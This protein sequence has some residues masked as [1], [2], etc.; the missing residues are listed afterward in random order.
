MTARSDI[1][2]TLDGRGKSLDSTRWS[3]KLAENSYGMDVAYADNLQINE[4][5]MSAW[6]PIA[7]GNARDGQ[8]DVLLVTGIDT[9]RHVKNPLVLLDHGKHIALPIGLMETRDTKQYTFAIDPLTK[10]AGGRCY[11]YQ[12]GN[13]DYLPAGTDPAGKAFL[14]NKSQQFEHAVLCEQL[15]DMMAKR[16]LRS[17]SIGYQVQ[18]A[19]RIPAD[20]AT[21]IPQGLFLKRVLMLEGSLVVLPANQDTVRKA[22]AMP[23]ICGRPP[24]EMLVKSL[25][26][27]ASKPNPVVI[28]GFSPKIDKTLS[29]TPTSEVRKVATKALDGIR[30]KYRQTKRLKRKL[31][32]SSKGAAVV[33]IER[34][35]MDRAREESGKLGLKFSHMGTHSSG[36]EKVKLIGDDDNIDHVAKMFGK[37]MSFGKSAKPLTKKKSLPGGNMKQVN[38]KTK[39]LPPEDPMM[40]DP[41]GAP[42][43]DLGGMEEPMEDEVYSAQVLRMIH[44]DH[45]ILMEEYDK[46]LKM[47]EHEHIRGFMEKLMTSID[48]LLTEVESLFQKFHPDLPALDGAMDKSLDEEQPLDDEALDQEIDDEMLDEA[49]DEEVVDDLM[50]EDVMEEG[51][52]DSADD[53][54]TE[55]VSEDAPET[56]DVEAIEEA[57]PDSTDDRDGEEPTSEDVVQGMKKDRGI[58]AKGKKSLP[59]KSLPRKCSKCGPGCKCA[60]CQKKYKGDK[61]MKE[62]NVRKPGPCPGEHDKKPGGGAAIPGRDG[63]KPPR[64]AASKPVDGSIDIPEADLPK[65]RRRPGNAGTV[66]PRMGGQQPE[67][68]DVT[69]ADGELAET[70]DHENPQGMLS[71]D[72][73]DDERHVVHRAGK[74]LNH[75]STNQDWTEESRMKAYYHHKSLEPIYGM[76]ERDEDHQPVD[77]KKTGQK[78]IPG[79]S[80]WVQEEGQE[81]DHGGPDHAHGS[82][83]HQEMHPA[84]IKCMGAGTFLGAL[85]KEKAFGEAHREQAGMLAKELESLHSEHN[86][87]QET[88]D[89]DEQDKETEEIPGDTSD[90]SGDPTTQYGGDNPGPDAAESDSLEQETPEPGEIGEKGNHKQST[91]ELARVL[92]DRSKRL[93]DIQRRLTSLNFN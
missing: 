36:R 78:S 9:S 16:L 13:S 89:H 29:N 81:A 1:F 87:E 6:I 59:Q 65:P 54:G 2:R 4:K 56:D 79:D 74:F 45:Q 53:S 3:Y 66:N 86:E 21:G 67:A 15:F 64:V 41:M 49:A 10:T 26:P 75:T 43:D 22:L 32:S 91:K 52:L 48:S 18:E 35:D 50:D 11:F 90:T 82:H 83:E 28:S 51:D 34:K 30:M 71:H 84:R 7:D 68:D 20:Y 46:A 47:L 27:Y 72:L 31:K 55:E 12:G 40:D 17:G 70:T 69:T 42:M 37:P 44:K 25:S 38:H 77:D 61:C 57:E 80:Q 63:A 85:S 73:S 23:R 8:G 5:E 93:Q 19:E 33:H 14:P 58:G 24:C 62:P 60:E 39:A 88:P 92:R 76:I